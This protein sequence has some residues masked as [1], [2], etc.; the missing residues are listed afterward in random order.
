MRA[1]EDIKSEARSTESM[2]EQLFHKKNYDGKTPLESLSK[3]EQKHLLEAVGR[4]A[5]LVYD[6]A[7]N[8]PRR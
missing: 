7:E 6:L 3:D 8:I 2:I 4:I 1:I 5:G